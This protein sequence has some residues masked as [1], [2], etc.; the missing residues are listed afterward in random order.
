MIRWT[1]LDP[2]KVE[3]AVKMLVRQLLPAA[4]GI[5]GTGGDSGRDIR[6][7]SPY[8]L[9][10][11]EV[12]SYSAR[13]SPGQR[14][15]VEASLA[16][17]VAHRPVGW[18]LI[19]PL[20]PSPSEE[21]WFDGL[22][23]RFSKITLEWRGR[24]W[25]DG[26]FAAHA[27]LRRYVEGSDYDLLIRARELG[28]EQAAL[29]NGSVDLTSRVNAL[30][31]GRG[32]ELS[33]YW[34]V[35]VTTQDDETI[36]RYSARVPD[37]ATQ[38]PVM[39]RP[40]FTFPANDP[41]AREVMRQLRQ[42]FDYGAAAAVDSRYVER[43]EIQA[44]EQTRQ[45]FGV[46]EH[47]PG[48]IQIGEAVHNE[49]LPLPVTLSVTTPT[50][51]TIHSIGITL[52]TRTV[53]LR[54]MQLIGSDASGVLTVTHILDNVGENGMRPGTFNF[55]FREVV[56]RYPYALRP[57]MDFVLAMQPGNRLAT[58]MGHARLGF[59]DITDNYLDSARPTARLIVALDELQQHFG[60]LFPVPD[61]LT[62]RD[63]EEYEV[64]RQLVAGEQAQWLGHMITTQIRA[65]RL[66]EFLESDAVKSEPASMVV[67]YEEM[68][69]TC[70][71]RSFNVGSVE[72]RG[73]RMRLTNRSELEEAIMAGIEA[74]ARWECID[75]ERL[76]I[77]RIDNVDASP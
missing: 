74:T 24:D 18:V 39:F 26:Q 72:I 28:H 51:D 33:P 52:T 23:E 47:E 64:A 13:L 57:V 49:S 21:S 37:A 1:S 4:Q 6:W 55:R 25:L 30:V 77:R 53:G 45:L 56:G 38:D 7:D 50:G 41:D 54:G 29:A 73:L 35:D 62:F 63:L 2:A 32:R 70:A 31:H 76:H 12:K 10:I 69:F 9:V 16:N 61:G 17:A 75:G 14:G 60:E 11:F 27:D 8:G 34:R 40:N 44:S 20:D 43:V 15:K 71:E 58:H 67:R 5:D 19:M 46:N 22:R 59:A 68:F 3:R 42:A 36:L 66:Q 65:D 48:S